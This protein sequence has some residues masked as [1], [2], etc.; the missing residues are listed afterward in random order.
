MVPMLLVGNYWFGV[1]QVYPCA[2]HLLEWPKSR[3]LTQA[4]A[5][6]D[7][8]QEELSVVASANAE[9]SSHRA[10]QLGNFLQKEI[11]PIM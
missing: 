4:P 9:P 6:M 10:R 1:M 11:H 2:A 5:G 7:V 3:T 8:G